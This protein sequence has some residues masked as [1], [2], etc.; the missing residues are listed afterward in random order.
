MM[1]S[2]PAFARSAPFAVFIGLLIVNSLAHQPWLVVVRGVVVAAALAW[3]W[4][5]YS[6]LRR[7]AEVRP[8]HWAL[9]VA[10]G[11]ATFLA[12]IWLDQ[13]WATL[14]PSPAF[15]PLH[16]DGRMNWPL[17]LLRLA[18]LALVVP[19]MEELFWRS[20]LLRW[21]ERHDF[22]SVAPAAVGLRAFAVTTVLFALEHDQ[23]LAGAIAATVYNALYM[24]AGNLWVPVLAHAVTNAALG[25]WVLHTENWNFW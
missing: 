9:A 25:V 5:E 1:V 18:G 10:A 19:L 14:S 3:F 16:E 13:D 21:L 8:S 24:R 11:L 12:W 6:E 2:R 17:A 15:D 20:F 7:P 22:L 23:W 4:R